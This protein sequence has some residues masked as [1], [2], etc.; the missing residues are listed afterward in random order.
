MMVTKAHILDEIELTAEAN[1]G[2]AL[3][4]LRFYAETGIKETDWSGKYWVRW[5][6]ALRE[7]GKKVYVD[8]AAS[9][10]RHATNMLLFMRPAFQASPARR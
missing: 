10:W 2:Q 7:A 1:G 4:R 8:G 9:L 5:S 3:G 6:D